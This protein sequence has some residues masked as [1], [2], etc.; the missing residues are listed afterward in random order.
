MFTR[1]EVLTELPGCC[2][3]CGSGDKPWYLDTNVIERMYGHVYYCSDCIADMLSVAQLDSEVEKR[4]QEIN[5]LKTTIAE[6]TATIAE[7]DHALSFIARTKFFATV[8]SV[9][10]IEVPVQ[11]VA[12][13]KEA[14]KPGEGTSPESG[15][16]KG[17][18]VVPDVKPKSRKSPTFSL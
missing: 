16:D 11:N 3:L 18:A 10:S 2:K 13:G 8:D 4:D 5:N 12:R 17:M 15:D 6:M 7:R 14:D 9:P 1:I